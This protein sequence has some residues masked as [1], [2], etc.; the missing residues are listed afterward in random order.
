MLILNLTLDTPAENLALD[1]ALLLVA[2]ESSGPQEV[3]RIFEPRQTFVVLGSSSRHGIEANGQACAADGVP[4][5]R[6]PSGGAAIVT[7]PG[8][9]MYAVVLSYEHHPHLAAIDEAHRYVLSRLATAIGRRIPGVA[10]AGVSDLA[11]RNRKFSGNSM[12]AKR[13]HLLYHGTLLYDFPLALVGRFLGAPP[14]QPEY[15]ANR[16]H[17]EFV[18]NLPIGREALCE[19]VQE[20]FDAKETLAEWPRDKTAR[21]VEEKYARDEWNRRL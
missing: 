15:R 1:E 21:L 19:A 13:R 11:I 20:A 18:T 14:R 8:C 2:E 5:L 12:R 3:V 4:I 7:G 10:P 9:L 16:S 17:S 6:R